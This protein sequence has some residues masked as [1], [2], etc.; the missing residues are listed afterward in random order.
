MK[1]ILELFINKDIV[2]DFTNEK[3]NFIC[4]S[5]LKKAL[6]LSASYIKEKKKYMVLCN[7]LH[8]AS[9]LYEYLNNLLKEENIITFFSDETIRIEKQGGDCT[10]LFVL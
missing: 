2:N 4:D 7:S 1:D 9:L 10:K 8:N 5:M 6:L 3:G